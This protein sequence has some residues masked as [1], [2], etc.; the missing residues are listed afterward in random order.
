ME[1]CERRFSIV[2]QTKPDS[3]PERVPGAPW[4]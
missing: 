3:K 1:N 2:C 4:N